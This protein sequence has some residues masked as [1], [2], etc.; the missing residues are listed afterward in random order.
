[1]WSAAGHCYNNYNTVLYR[2]PEIVWPS[3]F[4]ERSSECVLL[5]SQNNNELFGGSILSHYAGLT[6]VSL[7]KHILFLDFKYVIVH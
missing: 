6:W 1:V 7:P 5:I 3:I 4:V 2:C